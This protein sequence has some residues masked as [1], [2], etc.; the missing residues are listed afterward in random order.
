MAA[1]AGVRG[2][3]SNDSSKGVD[4]ESEKDALLLSTFHNKNPLEFLFT[5]E[6]LS[7]TSRTSTVA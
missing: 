6:G 5:S 7:S 2:F 3:S 4:K 1:Y